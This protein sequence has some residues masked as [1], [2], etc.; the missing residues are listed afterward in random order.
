VAR[1]R[2][3]RLASDRIYKMA[4]QRHSAD[5][6]VVASVLAATAALDMVLDLLARGLTP[7]TSSWCASRHRPI[8]WAAR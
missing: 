2:F 4:V 6:I 7:M 1:G 3:R 8:C 5:S